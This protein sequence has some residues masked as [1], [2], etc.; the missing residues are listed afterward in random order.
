MIMTVS[1]FKSRIIIHS[2]Y[3]SLFDW[4]KSHGQFFITS[5]RCPNLEDVCEIRKMTTI[6]KGD[7]QKKG[8]QPEKPGGRDFVFL[9]E[10]SREKMAHDFTR[11]AKKK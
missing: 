4:N 10:Q 3:S 8:R 7:G 5:Y 6:V 2:K 1:N 9:V 11:I